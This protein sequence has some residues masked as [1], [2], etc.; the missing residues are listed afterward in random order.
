MFS[1]RSQKSDVKV[2]YS[3]LSHVLTLGVDSEFP[4]YPASI[5]ILLERSRSSLGIYLLSHAPKLSSLETGELLD[6]SLDPDDIDTRLR[7]E[8]LSQAG[9]CETLAADL[10]A[11]AER[12]RAEARKDTLIYD[13]EGDTI[14]TLPLNLPGKNRAKVEDVDTSDV[15][16]SAFED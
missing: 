10:L 9:M 2:I 5:G 3:S 7:A 13:S 16:L 11:H 8:L 14:E 15:S 6:L 4:G 12:L 1:L